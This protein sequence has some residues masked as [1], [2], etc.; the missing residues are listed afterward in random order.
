MIS[1]RQIRSFV[2]VFEEGSF[3]RAAA[4]EGS[5]QSGVSQHV[6]QLEDQIGQALFIRQ[7]RAV[8][9]TA[10]GESYYRDCVE[11]LRRLDAATEKASAGDAAGHLRIGLMP[12][13]TRGALA[14]ALARFTQALPG[15]G[16][17]ITEAY[18]GV[19]T[20]MVR[21]G[22]LDFAVVPAFEGG[23]GLKATLLARDREMLVAARRAGGGHLK[24]A[25]PADVAGRNI[26]LPG[27]VN[28]RRRTLETYFATHGIAPGRRMELDAMIGTLEFVAQSD[29][30]A[31]LPSIMMVGD[32][33]TDGGCE[34]YD[35]RPLAEPPLHSDFVLIEPARQALSGAAQQFADMLREETERISAL[36]DAVLAG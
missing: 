33:T 10:V 17:H 30:V 31:V 20:D 11:T 34:R 7:G 5:T 16:V 29:W 21:A 25:G 8:A 32:L 13:F 9:P 6:R 12:S 35:I 28:T 27:P 36:W 23:L 22:D 4:R 15:A 19:L 18:S 14:P 3:T 1:L 24:P 2:S 26:I